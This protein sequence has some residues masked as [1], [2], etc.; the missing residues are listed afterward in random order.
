MNDQEKMLRA[1]GEIDSELIAESMTVYKKRSMPWTNK[2]AIAASVVLL[3]AAVLAM[4]G[5]FA[6]KSLDGNIA[7]GNA[8]SPNGSDSNNSLPPKGDHEDG[9]T[10]PGGNGTIIY[11]DDAGDILLPP[12]T[13]T[14]DFGDSP[15]NRPE[16]SVPNEG[17]G[18]D[19]DRIYLWGECGYVQDLRKD[20]S[21]KITFDLTL[22]EEC[23]EK[24]D[25]TILGANS[26]TGKQAICTS[27]VSTNNYD[28]ILS[29][30][31]TVDGVVAENFP[32]T[33]GSYTISIDYSAI[34]DTDY[35]WEEYIEISNFGIIKR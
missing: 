30:I 13:D 31:I 16:S 28:L 9:S 10:N 2:L 8:S 20:G 17:S 33:P 35:V 15:S 19:F 6:N 25:V 26:T 34:A 29:P 11:P 1:I 32:S 27:G 4:G 3:S 24:F 23:D 18:N 12:S 21:Y 5:L 14:G 22:L 7:G